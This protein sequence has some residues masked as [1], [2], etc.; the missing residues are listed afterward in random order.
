[1]IQ[2][3]QTALSHPELPNPSPSSSSPFKSTEQDSFS[4]IIGQ[5]RAVP[6][7]KEIRDG[8]CLGAP[9]HPLLFL[10]RSGHGKSSLSKAFADSI[11]AEFIR[12]DCGPELKSEHLV[13]KLTEIKS[14]AVVFCDEFQQMRKRVQT[15]LYSA[16][17]SSVVPALDRGRLD[18]CAPQVPIVPFMLI[19]ATNE[20]GRLLPALRSR[21]VNVVMDDYTDEDLRA[22]VVQKA[23]RFLVRLSERAIGL[24]VRASHGSPRSI[25]QIL[26]S[27]EVTSAAWRLN[28]ESEMCDLTDEDAG[29]IGSEL[30]SEL[31]SGLGGELAG[32]L[33][34]HSA[35][36]FVGESL[37]PTRPVT[38]LAAPSA[39][40][41]HHP[42]I[43]DEIVERALAWMG[44]DTA[45]L[46]STGRTILAT[47]AK[48]G[49][50]TAELISIVLGLDITYAREN[51]SQLR[52][53]SLLHAAP[54]RGWVLT[55]SGE[56]L[57][58]ELSLGS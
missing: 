58:K 54:G 20:P 11:G 43:P 18:R 8:I 1:M 47:V 34:E 9:P 27:V 22:I 56:K 35:L 42:L 44:L 39:S 17:D 21:M 29:D 23:N 32:D 5:R 7:L 52:S 24:V 28:Y 51:M 49:R 26:Q 36:D 41:A 50:A 6:F 37:M 31:G 30:V 15:V 16:L 45:G 57:V 2:A 10:G 55:D 40:S 4:R 3:I 19:G 12:I 53:R 25:V 13:E 38:Q 14:L 46:D 33:A 48:H